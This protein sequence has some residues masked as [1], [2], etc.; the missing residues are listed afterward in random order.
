M[1]T[2]TLNLFL[3]GLLSA[4]AALAL[5]G[6]VVAADVYQACADANN[7][8]IR[9]S[10]IKVNAAAT[11]AAREAVHSWNQNGPQGPQGPQ[12]LQGPAGPSAVYIKQGQ[13][14]VALPVSPDFF[15]AN[16][17]EVGSIDLPGGIYAV[18]VTV[19][20]ISN[21]SA[22]P[23]DIADATCVITTDDRTQI[24]NVVPSRTSLGLRQTASIAVTG[25]A[26]S[27]LP[28]TFRVLCAN[29][30]PVGDVLVDSYN[31]MAIKVGAFFQP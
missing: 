28:K 30:A 2:R 6:P 4:A 29:R 17:T 8:Q 16:Y 14:L 1:S 9:P 20:G 31:I 22:N 19:A 13:P 24:A 3:R 25:M 15:S 23:G 26:H 7:H 27:P 5:T 11:C 12:G 10:S 21:R 18:T